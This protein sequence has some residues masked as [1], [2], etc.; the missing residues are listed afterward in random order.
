M[1]F[2]FFKKDMSEQ[3]QL[4][5]KED[6]EML[7]NAEY[8]LTEDIFYPHFAGDVLREGTI[9][10]HS[11]NYRDRRLYKTKIK[12]LKGEVDFTVSVER[13]GSQDKL[14]HQRSNQ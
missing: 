5:V 10:V 3:F 7:K 1:G 6:E 2:L 9:L 4:I 12:T 8:V 11:G 13:N 14:I